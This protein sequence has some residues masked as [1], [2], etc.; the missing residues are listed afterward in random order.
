V[1][2]AIDDLLSIK[3]L[4]VEFR[5]LAGHVQA[6]NR[7]SLRLKPGSTVALV[8]E[9]GSGKS[10]TAQAVLGI[11]PR[12]AFITEG[13]ILFRDPAGAVQDLA[14]MPPRSKRFTR[15][16]GDRIGMIFRSR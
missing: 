3:D 11:L 12:T 9:S 1:G 14:K 13:E 16:R 10:V 2:A 7:M 6:V 15:I 5:T 8:G 4:S